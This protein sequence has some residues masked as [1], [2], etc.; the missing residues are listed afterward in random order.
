MTDTRKRTPARSKKILSDDDLYLF[1]EG[2][3]LRLYRKLGAQR[4]PRSRRNK[5]HFAVWAPDADRVSVIGSFNDWNGDADPMRPIGSS[6]VWAASVNDVTEGSTYK[7]LIHSRSTDETLEKADPYAFACEVPPKT[8][9]VVWSLDYQWSDGEW[10][11]ERYQRNSLEAPISIYEVHLG[12]WRRVP[13][14]G[15]RSLSYR[16]LAHQLADYV[17]EAGFTHVEFTPVMEHPFFGSWGYQVTG[18]FAPS[19]RFGTPQDFMYLVD[20]LHQRGIGVI[21]DWVPSHFPNDS[22]GLGRFDGTHLYEHADPRQGIHP[23]WNSYVFNYGRNEVR[24]F[25][26]SSAMYWLDVYHADGLR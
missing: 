12:S 15:N 8:A 19:S 24:S 9:S 17:L 11:R 18:Y 16:E 7:Y 1:N 4:E 23:D 13:E 25:L 10:M 20:Y 5:V 22:Y 6:G 2:R 26:L 14:E 3:H 21:L